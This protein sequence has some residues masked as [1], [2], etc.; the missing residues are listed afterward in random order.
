MEDFIID[1]PNRITYEHELNEILRHMEKSSGS[2]I[3]ILGGLPI[4][5]SR[6]GLKVPVTRRKIQDKEVVGILSMIY[7]DNAASMIGAGER[8][9]TSHDFKIVTGI[10]D[11]DNEL[12]ERFRYRVNAVSCLRFGN[13]SATL[14]IRSIPTTPKRAVEIGIEQD[15]ID[16]FMN[17]FMM[18]T[19]CQLPSIL[20]W[21]L[22]KTLRT[23]TKV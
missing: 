10:D 21:R 22:A 2:D 5:M 15:I 11:H 12:Y 17:L 23:S 20:R 14:T 19:I 9:D 1:V 16:V 6:H 8:I 3:F 7:G 13:R 4:K 18:V